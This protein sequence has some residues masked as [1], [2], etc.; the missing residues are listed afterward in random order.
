M[1]EFFRRASESLIAR[2]FFGLLAISFAIM[3]GG[4]EGLRMIGIS[5]DATVA[6]VGAETITNRDLALAIERFR[7][8]SELRGGGELTMKE[9][10]ESGLDRQLLNML[11]AES[12]VRQE[13]VKL[14]ITVSDDY[15]IKQLRDNQ[16]FKRADGTFSKETFQRFIS[17]FG[18]RT[19][20]EYV[21]YMK[22]EILR[23]RVID[24]LAANASLPVVSQ[25]PLFAWSEQVR[26]AS[27]MILD[28]TAIKV[29]ENPSQDDLRDFYGKYQ[30]QFA[31]PERRTFKALAIPVASLKIDV[32]ESDI[33]LVYDIEK[34]KKYKD[35]KDTIAREEIREQLRRE[36]AQDAVL[37]ISSA[38]R[39]AFD[40][41]ASLKD[42]AAKNKYDLREFT[43][44]QLQD[45]KGDRDQAEQNMIEYAFSVV[46]G[47]L[48]AF[49]EIDS[50]K[51]YV[52]IFL[53]AVMEPSQLTFDQAM[54]DVRDAFMAEKRLQKTQELVKDIETQLA[55][56]K[57][58][59]ALAMQ[60]KLKLVTL[61]ASRQKMLS[62]TPED[63]L[64]ARSDSLFR[65]TRSGTTVMPF[66]SP[67]KG[68]QFAFAKITE[69]RNGDAQKDPEGFRR[70]VERLKAQSRDDVFQLYESDLRTRYSVEVNE[71]Y[72]K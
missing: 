21:D 69:I 58:F 45:K 31:V 6:T 65:T 26:T 30:Q 55:G 24:A 25:E 1:I 8:L 68:V 71:R 34:D 32:K 29:D 5:R 64:T 39:D 13:A 46:E 60:N 40:E 18:F 35:V 48:S 17:N 9:V 47:E 41:G 19:E 53:E 10:R 43:E 23:I 42:I 2:I 54:A 50:G 16:M 33:D 27:A 57:P 72:F 67:G 63:L 59:K 4:Q 38:V 15:V 7:I 22:S 37:A 52:A 66:V 56:G 61:R 14:D 49:E 44:V 28:T 12:L 11:I 51:A 3:W 36:A 70:F 20:K 62:P